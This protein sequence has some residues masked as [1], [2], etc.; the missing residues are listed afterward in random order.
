MSTGNDEF[1]FLLIEDRDEFL[2]D[3]TVEAIQK[4]LQL[5]WQKEEEDDNENFYKI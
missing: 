3:D 2:G 5:L 4:G 1:E